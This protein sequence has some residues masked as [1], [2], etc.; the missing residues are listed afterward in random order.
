[1]LQADQTEANTYDFVDHKKTVIPTKEQFYELERIK[2]FT[3]KRPWWVSFALRVLMLGVLLVNVPLYLGLVWFTLSLIVLYIMH[4]VCN[5]FNLQAKTNKNFSVSGMI[6]KFQKLKATW[7]F[8][9]VILGCASVLAQ[10]WL[11]VDLSVI[12]HTVLTAVLYLFLTRNCADKKFMNQITCTILGTAFLGGVAL[13]IRSD[14]PSKDLYI[15]LGF[16]FYLSINA[17]MLF[18]VGGRLNKSFKQKCISDYSNLQLIESLKESQEKLHVEQEALMSANTVIQQFYS[19]AAHDL[20]QPVYA[21]ELYTDMLRDDPTQMDC[22][23][24]KI[25]QSCMSINHMFND[26]FDFQQKHLNDSKLEYTVLDISDTLKSVALHFEPIATAKNLNISF[27]PLEGSVQTIP[28]Y[29]V[30]ILSNLIANAI[31]Y[32]PTGRILV[33]AR[34]TEDFLSFEVWDTGP[35]IE[36]KAQEKIFEEFYKINAVDKKTS[37][38]GLGLSIV[39]GLAQ[40]ID[41]AKIRVNSRVGHGSV[42]KLLLPIQT[43]STPQTPQAVVSTMHYSI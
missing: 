2:H 25:S 33:A 13:L 21:M 31:T 9:A 42:F 37:N 22:L 14:Q 23:L 1:M 29:F 11:P 32:T 8:G 28:L 20:R 7:F 18:L 34:K 5:D 39:K 10:F 6:H 41:G 30:R 24:P 26:L 4:V 38:L 15:F 35:G 16:C 12:L 19:A 27:K 3:Q 36:K 40:R 17:F 43:Y